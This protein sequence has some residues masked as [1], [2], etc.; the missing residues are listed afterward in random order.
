MKKKY[1]FVFISLLLLPLIIGIATAGIF[2]FQL[3]KNEW[4]ML[5]TS[6]SATFASIL[7]GC[8]VFYQTENHKKRAEKMEIEHDKQAQLYQKEERK[9]RAQDLCLRAAPAIGVDKICDFQFTQGLNVISNCDKYNRL[10]KKSKEENGVFRG[11]NKALHINIRFSLLQ[12]A[13]VDNIHITSASLKVYLGDPAEIS[14]F[15]SLY[16][17]NFINFN[18]DKHNANTKLDTDGSPISVL[19]LLTDDETFDLNLICNKQAKWELLIHFFSSNAFNVEIEYKMMIEF[20]LKCEGKSKGDTLFSIK[21]DKYYLI[22]E[23]NVHF[24][25][26]QTNESDS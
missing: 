12:N 17:S 8:I 13:I 20:Q 2:N 1:L 19:S 21:N 16:D 26:E 3:E 22:Q 23:S 4:I 6:C 9:Y 10:E 11:Y 7:L 15:K 25:K 18:H 5:I 24:K 14:T